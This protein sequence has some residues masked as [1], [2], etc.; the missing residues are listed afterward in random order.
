LEAHEPREE[1]AK[2]GFLGER[3]KYLGGE[4]SKPKAASYCGTTEGNATG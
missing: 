1:K 4:E 3:E 2:S